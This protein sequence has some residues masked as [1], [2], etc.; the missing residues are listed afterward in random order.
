M[1]VFSRYL[2]VTVNKS[3]TVSN[4]YDYHLQKYQLKNQKNQKKIQKEKNLL[5]FILIVLV[6]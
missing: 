5:I 6:A 4:Y 1:Y 2:I 3:P